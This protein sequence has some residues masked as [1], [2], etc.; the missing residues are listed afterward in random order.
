MHAA[1]QPPLQVG[2]VHTV[3]ELL[4]KNEPQGWPF[5]VII[6]INHLGN[7]WEIGSGVD[8]VHEQ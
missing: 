2:G 6:V 7:D 3:S 5:G 1:V 4:H 8:R